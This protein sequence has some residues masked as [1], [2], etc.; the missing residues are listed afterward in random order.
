MIWLPGFSILLFAASAWFFLLFLTTWERRKSPDSFFFSLLLLAVI[1]WLIP[2]GMEYLLPTIEQKIW[3]SKIS[4]IGVVTVAVFIFQTIHA[5]VTNAQKVN[6]QLLISLLILPTILLFFV[7]TNGT[8]HTWLWTDITPIPGTRDLLLH[9]QHGIIHTLIAFYSYSLVIGSVLMLIYHAFQTDIVF[10]LRYYILGIA[11]LLPVIGNILYI[12]ELLPLQGIDFSVV[13]FIVSSVMLYFVLFKWQIFDLRPIAYDVLL[14]SEKRGAI[15]IDNQDRIIMINHAIQNCFE[16]PKKSIGKTIFDVFRNHPS[17]LKAVQSVD[18]NVIFQ[19]T[20][21]I[22]EPKERMC[23]IQK[24]PILSRNEPLGTLIQV[25]DVSQRVL[26]QR[27]LE[28]Q[29]QLQEALLLVSRSLL[30]QDQKWDGLLQSIIYIKKSLQVESVRIVQNVSHTSH[31]SWVFFS[32]DSNSITNSLAPDSP[33]NAPFL[34]W[35]D[36]SLKP[37]IL[38]TLQKCLPYVFSVDSVSRVA[39]NSALLNFLANHSVALIPILSKQVAT[40]H[41]TP[42]TADQDAIWGVIEVIRT[43]QHL[44]VSNDFLHSEKQMME[45]VGSLYSEYMMRKIIQN[46]LQD[47]MERFEQVVNHTREVI[48]EVDEEMNFTYL[49]NNFKTLFLIPESISEKEWYNKQNF[50]SQFFQI[51]FTPTGSL[52]NDLEHLDSRYRDQYKELMERF[53]KQQPIE[54][55]SFRVLDYQGNTLYLLLNATP[56]FNA[57]HVFKGYRGSAFDITPLK[58]LEI[59]KDSFI[60]TVSHEFR[61]PLFA[62][63]ESISMVYKGA[64]GSLLPDQKE[65]LELCLRNADRLVRLIND[66]LNLQKFQSGRFTPNLAPVEPL[67]IIREAFFSIAPL[68]DQKN[69]RLQKAVAEDC[70]SLNIDKDMI[71]Q[72]LVNIL[73]NAVKYTHQGYVKVH[74][75]PDH[76]SQDK[77]QIEEKKAYVHIEVIDS[78][79]GIKEEDLPKLFKTFSQITTVEHPKSEGTGL[80]LVISKKIIDLHKGKIWVQSSWGKGST[81]HILLPAV[82]L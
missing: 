6:W 51:Q 31:N 39:P 52:E 34:G 70:P 62:I 9:Y 50:I 26:N 16:I 32:P 79:I 30:S 12:G 3:C 21:P 19:H 43:K 40:K 22:L 61:T 78:G 2:Q 17:F 15:V 4:Y 47:S 72:V 5:F 81:F 64:L 82:I 74:A 73:S 27:N 56:I 42:L 45:M 20:S 67:A 65:T 28:M 14:K 63:R 11:C 29:N 69:I 35:V 54:D 66:I 13:G 46:R 68:A 76:W 25:Y 77:E 10:R 53:E 48:W 71:V 38:Q 33:A 59:M 8:F 24:M 36:P 80:G 41:S 58:Q 18:H 44:G 49:S 37:D 75:F 7:F 55:L 1:A 23:E 60:N 57:N